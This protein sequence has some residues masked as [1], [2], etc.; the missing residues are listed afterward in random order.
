MTRPTQCDVP[1]DE[2]DDADAEAAAVSTS[3]KAREMAAMDS[4]LK[5]FSVSPR[6]KMNM[7]PSWRIETMAAS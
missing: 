6:D 5:R 4:G 2:D 7:L 1:L 3:S